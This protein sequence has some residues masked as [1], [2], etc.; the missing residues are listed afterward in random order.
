MHD[1][2]GAGV[3]NNNKKLE[4]MTD[5]NF[6]TPEE[7]SAQDKPILDQN[8]IFNPNTNKHR[9]SKLLKWHL[10]KQETI[11]VLTITIL[12]L[13]VAG[14]FV[15]NDLQ[16]KIV[17][18]ST[19][20]PII[21][22]KS[23]I[24]KPSNLVPSTLS[25]QL[26]PPSV[27]QRPITAVMIENTPYARPQSGLSQANVVI[28][29]LTEGGITRFMALYQSNLP[30]YLGPVRSLRP[31]FLDW[32]MGFNAPIAHVGGSP[33]ALSE[34]NSLHARNL[35]YL[36]YP[37]Y[38][39]RI[40]SR[41]AP[42]NVYTSLSNLLKLEALKG[43][44]SSDFKGWPRQA[45]DPSSKPTV[46]NINF[47]MSYSTY[48][49]NYQYDQQTNSYNRSEG[50]APQIGA[51]SNKQISPQVVIGMVVPWSQGSLD[52]SDAYYSVYQDIGSGQV[53]VFQNGQLTT[54][55]WYKPSIKAP[56][57]FTTDQGKPLKLNPGQ[58]WITVIGSS[59]DLTYN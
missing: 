1:E 25:G 41:P 9:M 56:L 34:V 29:A 53:Y 46:T 52:T 39:E 30:S 32:A 48:N 15:Y 23:K 42:H 6:K 27:N 37:S 33:Q 55:K 58:T 20:K 45:A 59:N 21:S 49:V 4:N 43:Y 47:D 16:H 19:E 7:I 44:T 36:L 35:D 10:T 18:V 31:Y 51:N 26:V 12:A 38:Y 40:A 17:A 3:Q 54:G 8:E 2:M 14:L 50:G 24:A 28:E 13:I 57:S 11:I 5:Q 22:F